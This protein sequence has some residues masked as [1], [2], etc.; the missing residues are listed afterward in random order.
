MAWTICSLA[1][2]NSSIELKQNCDKDMDLDVGMEIVL[3]VD[4]GSSM[5]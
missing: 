1:M 3:G 5:N 4:W 2:L